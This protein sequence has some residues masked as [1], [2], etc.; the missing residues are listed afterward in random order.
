MV[1]KPLSRALLKEIKDLEPDK[2]IIVENVLENDEQLSVA[3]FFPQKLKH[4]GFEEF[5]IQVDF[6]S[7]FVL[8]PQSNNKLKHSIQPAVVG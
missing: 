3:N 8:W 1:S 2:I 7:S 6:F 4:L 5:N